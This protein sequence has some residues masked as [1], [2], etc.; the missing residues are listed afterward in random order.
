[1]SSIQIQRLTEVLNLLADKVFD[2]KQK[3]FY[4]LIDKLDEN[5]AE[6]ETRCRF[7]RALIE[8]TKSM[9]K[10][11]QVKIITALRIDLLEMV[12]DKT[13]GSGFQEEKYEA[14][15]M[16]VVWSRD[17][18]V[19][20][21]SRRVKEVYKRQYTSEDVGF[22]DVFP[23]SSEEGGES[24]IDYILNRTFMR[25]RDAIQFVNECF[26]IAMGRPRV[27]LGAI[28]SAESH[29]SNKRMKSLFEEWEEYYPDLERTIEILRGARNPVTRSSLMERIQSLSEELI[30]GSDKD[31]CVLVAKQMYSH[32]H[33]STK[34]DL[35]VEVISCLYQVGVLGVKVSTNEP[36]AWS[37]LAGP[38]ISRSEVKRINQIEIH[39]MF[40]HS[41]EVK[42]VEILRMKPGNVNVRSK[43]KKRRPHSGVRK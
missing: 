36:I 42:Q 11:P 33:T 20:L 27:S 17:D 39:P 23:T 40:S 38:T 8:E 22:M 32:E 18:L 28:R 31:P 1:V 15:L 19:D 12:F 10:I 21:L 41:L 7:I 3:C 25:P 34:Q 2:D 35:F 43:Q 24:C 9:R 26:I 14:Y 30:K 5:W 4:I 16:K 37:Y 13:R 6:T 29:Y